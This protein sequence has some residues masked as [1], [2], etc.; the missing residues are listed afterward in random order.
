MQFRQ[1]AFERFQ[2][3]GFRFLRKL[4]RTGSF[5]HE[6]DRLVGEEPIGNVPIRVHGGCDECGIG[7]LYSE[8]GL[9]SGSKTTQDGDGGSDAGCFNHDG[10]KSTSERLVL[11][12]VFPVFIQRRG[13]D[14]F[15]TTSQ[16][17]LD[18]VSSVKRSFRFSKIE[19][20]V[21]F[22][23]KADNSSFGIRLRFLNILQEVLE[24]LLKLP[25]NAAAGNKTRQVDRE[26]PLLL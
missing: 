25:T 12:D 15:E 26:Q 9:V 19:K 10:L 8:V 3:V 22:V 21:K 24:L 6:I 7:D 2:G 13:A 14:E 11:L 17:W 23:D 5:V 4:E 16:G 18:H 1:L 20:G